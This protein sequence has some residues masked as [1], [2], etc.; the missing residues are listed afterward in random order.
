M[1]TGRRLIRTISLAEVREINRS[2]ILELI[3]RD[4][5]I[6]RAQ[7]SDELGVSLTSVIRIV[8]ELMAEGLV[9]EEEKKEWSG[10][11]KRTRVRFNGSQHLIL[12]IDL[13]GTKIYGAVANF[14][15]DI[16]HETR[17]DCHETKG[18]QSLELLCQTIDHL[19]SF[20]LDTKLPIKGI[21]V[22]VPGIVVPESGAVKIAPAL[23]WKDFP[24][25]QQLVE[26][27]SLPIAI[28]NDVNLAAL[29]ELWFGSGVDE[30]DLV[31]LTIGTGIGAGIII[32][33][34]IYNGARNM[35]GEVGYFLPDRSCL[36]QS[37]PGFGALEQFVS[38]TGIA[39]RARAML[40]ESRSPLELESLT[41]QSVFEAARR[42]EG[43][44]TA[45]MEE[46][47]DYLAQ[48]IA[49]ITTIFDPE[50]ILLGGGVY[51]S[52]DLLIEPI[53]ERLMG[54]L[55]VVPE[56]RPSKLGDRA[57]VMGAIVQLLRITSN[58]YLLQKFV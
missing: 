16:L 52:S 30:S 56:V 44:A 38:G 5:P 49:A 13:G 42:A 41:A 12:G 3:R 27:Y 6:S 4:S 15:G 23:D 26:R 32:N 54:A 31:L 36:G 50:M 29:G 2:S 58:Y 51:K 35:A 37:Y 24:L 55:L 43:W 22:G 9:V 53:R 28:E 7:I 8:D 40:R 17:I 45:V 19:L 39:N 1:S 14:N 11:R 48:L 21:G 18:D 33:G 57:A 10:G 25:K 20:A 34:A 46:T 47:I